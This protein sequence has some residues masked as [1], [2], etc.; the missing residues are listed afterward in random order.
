MFDINMNM[1]HLTDKGAREIGAEAV[2]G[3]ANLVPSQATTLIVVGA[4]FLLGGSWTALAFYKEMARSGSMRHS[5]WH[6]CRSKGFRGGDRG[7][8]RR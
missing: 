5:A 1:P 7:I 8:G 4:I 2:Q 3:L 6:F